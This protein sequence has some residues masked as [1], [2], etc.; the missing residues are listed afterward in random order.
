MRLKRTTYFHSAAVSLF[1]GSAIYLL[2]RS[3]SLLMFR[4]ATALR[5]LPLINTLRFYSHGFEPFI[6]AW[7]IYSSPFA[8]WI[9]SYMLLVRAIWFGDKSIARNLWLWAVPFVSIAAEL[10]QYPRL[11]PGT[12]DIFDLL[13]IIAAIAFAF[14]I[15]TFDATQLRK[16]TS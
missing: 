4:W 3:E 10:G 13:T 9:V 14:A 7:F 15:I 11:V 5:L 12:F 16:E 2:F 6:P 8:L 1:L